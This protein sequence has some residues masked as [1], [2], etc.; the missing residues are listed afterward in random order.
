MFKVARH[1]MPREN[2]RGVSTLVTTPVNRFGN[3]ARRPLRTS[4]RT[5]HPHL[6]GGKLCTLVRSLRLAL[7]LCS[8]RASSPQVFVSIVS[9]VLY[10]VFAQ[11]GVDSARLIVFSFSDSVV[12]PQSPHEI[13]VRHRCLQIVISHRDSASRAVHLRRRWTPMTLVVTVAKMPKPFVLLPKPVS[14]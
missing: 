4:G 11:F 2:C 1:E 6:T 7:V 3:R 14:E 13:E 9:A 10:L 8:A 12:S 5:A